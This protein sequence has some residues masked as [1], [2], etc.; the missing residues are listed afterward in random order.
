VPKHQIFKPINR[1]LYQTPEGDYAKLI[2]NSFKTALFVIKKGDKTI[3]YHYDKQT[4]KR[5]V[6]E[7]ENPF[8]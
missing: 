5:I 4:G 7:L 8:V 1:T 6:R 2:T 3:E